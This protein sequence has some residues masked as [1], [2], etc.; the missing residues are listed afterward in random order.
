MDPFSIFLDFELVNLIG[1]RLH[2][3]GE[4]VDSSLFLIVNINSLWILDSE[5]S[6]LSYSEVMEQVSYYYL[7]DSTSSSHRILHT[8]LHWLP[9]SKHLN[10]WLSLIVEFGDSLLISF[11]VFRGCSFCHSTWKKHEIRRIKIKHEEDKK[12]Y[13]LLIFIVLN[14]GN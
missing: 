11:A 12:K 1:C 9:N 6:M 8:P 14:I 7:A 13:Y 3:Y 5:R 4:L 2:C 10:C